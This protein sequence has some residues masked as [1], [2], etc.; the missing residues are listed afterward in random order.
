MQGALKSAGIEPSD[1]TVSTA[2]FTQAL[3]SA[4]GYAPILH[5]HNDHSSGYSYIDE[6]GRCHVQQQSDLFVWVL[7][8]PFKAFVSSNACKPGVSSQVK[9]S[10]PKWLRVL[11]C[12]WSCCGSPGGLTTMAGWRRCG[13]ALTNTLGRSWTAMTLAK[14]TAAAR[15]TRTSSAAAPSSMMTPRSAC[16]RPHRAA[17]CNAMRSPEHATS[18]CTCCSIAA[19]LAPGTWCAHP[20]RNNI[21]LV[22][23]KLNIGCH[24]QDS[25]VL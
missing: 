19:P 17:P 14:S 5:C 3:T 2:A 18:C 12:L 8:D 21:W 15:C 1:N 24:A 25:S 7:A 4:F 11:Y 9:Q 16:T 22:L 6:V 20:T 13:N 23:R 10:Q